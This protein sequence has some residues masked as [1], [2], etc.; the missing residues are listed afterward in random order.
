[1]GYGGN[2]QAVRQKQA[3]E[4]LRKRVAGRARKVWLLEAELYETESRRVAIKEGIVNLWG[5]R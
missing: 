5:T 2:C 1:L 3:K 4:S